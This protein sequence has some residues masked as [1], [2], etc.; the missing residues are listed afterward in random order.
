MQWYHSHD[1]RKRLLAL[2]VGIL[3]GAIGTAFLRSGQFAATFPTDRGA[4]AMRAGTPSFPA[5]PAWADREGQ[6][7][8]LVQMEV[9]AYCHCEKCCG[10]WAKIPILDRT[11][12]SGESLA[13]LLVDN[14]GFVAAG[15]LIPY[16]TEFEIPDYHDGQ[17]VAVRDRG[18][19]DEGQIEVF[20]P[21]HQDAVDWGVKV[22]WVK[23]YPKKI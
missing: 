18:P 12:A 21:N 20:F 23:V 16:G 22:L 19:S 13:G 8:S 3:L 10:D 11:T 14:A 17:R 1:R 9:R 4:W 2:L 6:D 7:W 15:P 5:A